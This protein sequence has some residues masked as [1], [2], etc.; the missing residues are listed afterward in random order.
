MTTYK[1]LQ[2]MENFKRSNQRKTIL[3]FLWFPIILYIVIFITFCL[4]D[5]NQVDN[6]MNEANSLFILVI[7]VCIIRWIVSYY[8]EKDIMFK[9]SWAKELQRS[10]NPEL[11]NIVENLCIANWIPMPKIAI[12]NEPGM[13]AF[14]LWVKP[15]ESR[16]AFTKW[17]VENLNRQEIEAVAWHELTHI[18]NKD[19]LL[20]YFAIVYIWIFTL[21]GTLLYEWWYYLNL[22][23]KKSKTNSLIYLLGFWFIILWY[24]VYP[25]MRLAISRKREYMADLWSVQLTHDTQAMI[26]ALRKISWNP[27]VVWANEQISSLFIA[28]PLWKNNYEKSWL[29]NYASSQKRKSTTSRLDSHPSIEDRI[30][31]LEQYIQD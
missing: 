16:V 24:T 18:L 7:I 28:E 3:I 27:S 1:W 6:I 17:L 20:S 5:E 9:L 13:N 2:W 30:A 25:L 22:G 29:E 4:I 14:A 15:R 10:E 19:C 23:S 26:S 12:I 31:M 11:Y 8:K 21:L